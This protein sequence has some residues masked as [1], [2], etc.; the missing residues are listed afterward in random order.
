MGWSG[1]TPP[2]QGL[3]YGCIWSEE[4]GGIRVTSRAG[5]PVFND[6]DLY[7]MGLL[8]AAGV[9]D[10]FVVT[11]PALKNTL[12]QGGCTGVLYPKSAF[13]RVR[14]SDMLTVDPP[15]IPPYA[16]SP[17]KFNIV[18]VL[19]SNGRLLTAEEL[20]FFDYFTQRAESKVE[21]PYALGFGKGTA[22]PFYVST[23]GLGSM[24]TRLRPLILE[25][26]NVFEFHHAGLNHYFRTGDAGEAAY[27]R[28]NPALGFL[29]TGG[30]FKA[31]TVAGRSENAQEVCRFYGSVVP[32]PNS[33]FYTADPGE[34]AY[35][36]SLQAATPASQRRWNFEAIA[37]AIDLPGA[38]GLC[39]AGSVPVYRLYNNGFARGIDS[40]HRLTTS[41]ALYNQMQGPEWKGEGIVMCAV[42]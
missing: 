17:K 6:M 29:D 35:L 38:N 3:N 12:A 32:G 27:L 13:Q 23:G 20:A 16:S 33:H 25:I 18:T 24:D 15:R 39:A 30:T 8:P 9:A 26:I 21:V 19:L 22:K 10:H 36:K 11:D 2:Y 28:G 7:W 40:N 41:L 34:C 4:A 1:L 31:H 42:P 5:E 37:F 14:L